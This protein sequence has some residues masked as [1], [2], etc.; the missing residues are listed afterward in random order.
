MFSQSIL[1]TYSEKE[2]YLDFEIIFTKIHNCNQN[3]LENTFVACVYQLSS[4][5]VSLL[6][7][8]FR[9]IVTW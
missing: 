4:Y 8:K 3:T 2:D 9:K 6:K 1:L 7:R 5:L